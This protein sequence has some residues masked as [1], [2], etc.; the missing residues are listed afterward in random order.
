[1]IVLP[2]LIL[3]GCN[4]ERRSSDEE[5]SIFGKNFFYDYGFFKPKV[6][7]SEADKTITW[8]VREKTEAIKEYVTEKLSYAKKYI[9][10]KIEKSIKK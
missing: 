3:F 5:L 8:Q 6:F 7:Y 9:R 2:L 4:G 10:E 1:M